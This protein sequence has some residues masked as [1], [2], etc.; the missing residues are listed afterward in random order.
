MRNL[1]RNSIS[2]QEMDSHSSIRI[3]FFVAGLLK[4]NIILLKR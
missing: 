2:S 1:K 4:I 3:D